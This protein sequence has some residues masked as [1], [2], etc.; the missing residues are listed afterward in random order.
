MRTVTYGMIPLGALAG[1]AVG[2]WAGARTGLVIGSIL[3]L[4]TVIWVAC[5]PLPT[6]R[7][8]DELED[9]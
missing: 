2:D 6:I 8:I 3:C 5:S 9:P 1:G 4:G 7:R